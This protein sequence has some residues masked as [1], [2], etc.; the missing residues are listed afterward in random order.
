MSYAFAGAAQAA[1]HAALTAHPE[2]AALATGGVHDEPPQGAAGRAATGPYVLI[3]DEAVSPWGAGD[4]AGAAHAVEIAVVGAALG[5][6]ALKRIAAAVS[7]AALGPLSIQGA[8]V[9]SARFLGART[10]RG[11]EGMRR[12]DLRFRLIVEPA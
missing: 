10:R 7:D 9:V 5:F 6:A 3:G 12:I 11:R 8:R 1:L 4:L 2:I